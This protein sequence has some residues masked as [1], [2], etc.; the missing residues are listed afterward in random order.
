MTLGRP[1]IQRSL[2]PFVA[3][4][5][6]AGR[7]GALAHYYATVLLLLRI[8]MDLLTKVLLTKTVYCSQLYST[9][10][11]SADNVGN[12]LCSVHLIRGLWYL[13]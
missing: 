6:A 2:A 1:S 12:F 10:F 13:M 9:Y 5:W 11:S 8:K 7:S 3:R 4:T